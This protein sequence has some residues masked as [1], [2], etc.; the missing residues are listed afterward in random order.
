LCPPI[1][2]CLPAGQELRYDNATQTLT[3]TRYYSHLGATVAVRTAAGL[4]WLVA[5]H[6]GTAEVAVKASDLQTVGHRR[7]SP[8]G[9]VRGGVPGYWAGDQGF[10]GGTQDPT[11]L[12]HLGARLYDPVL[13]RFISVDP[14]IDVYDPQQMHG[15]AYG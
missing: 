2:R 8:F 4:T 13:G 15:Y 14:V 11:G 9:Q 1:R 7:T 6:H 12:T 3:C 10:V 5:D